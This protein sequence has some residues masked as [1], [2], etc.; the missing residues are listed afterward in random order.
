MLVCVCGVA[1]Q[2]TVDFSYSPSVNFDEN[3]FVKA[4]IGATRGIKKCFNIV[5]R[6]SQCN[7]TII[8]KY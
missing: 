8:A 2:Y 7:L 1:Y 5:K 4:G 3:S 6:V